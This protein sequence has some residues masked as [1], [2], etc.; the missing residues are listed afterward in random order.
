MT[1]TLHRLIQVRPIQLVF[2]GS[3]FLSAFLLFLVQP[4]VTRMLLPVY[5]G[6]PAVWNTALV[7][8]QVL[9]LLGYL[10]AFVVSRVRSSRATVVLHGAVVLLPVLVLPPAL[11][12]AMTAD[13]ATSTWPAARLLLTLGVLVGAP[14]FALSS[15]SS[16]IQWWWSRSGFRDSQ[17]P[18]WLYGASNSGSLLALLLYPFALERAFGVSQQGLLWAAGYGGF[19]VLTAAVMF[20]ALVRSSAS[21]QTDGLPETVRADPDQGSAEPLPVRRVLLW[22]FRSAVGSS[23]LLSVSTQITTDL[24]PTPLLWV[25]PLAL[26]LVTFILAFSVTERLH[27]P[28]LV[29]AA[30]AFLFG[31]LGLLVVG[32]R[33]RFEITLAIS[34]G[35]LFFGALLCHRD[36]AANRPRTAHLTAFYLW[37]S[38]GG[39]LGGTLNGLVAPLVFDSVAELPL[40][41]MALALLLYVDPETDRLAAYRPTWRA[42]LLV[43]L[44]LIVP[45]ISSLNVDGQRLIP[46]IVGVTVLWCLASARYVGMVGM[47]VVIAGGLILADPF[48]SG[49]V[50]ARERSFFGVIWVRDA[51]D[52]L[53]ML[54]GSTIHGSQSK[55]PAQRRLPGAYYHTGG[56]LGGA[57]LQAADSARIGI[58][59]LGTGGLAGLGRPGQHITYFEIDPL[60]EVMARQYFSFLADSPARVD[61]R[62]GDGRLEMAEL[63]DDSFDLLIVDAF[64]SDFIPIHLLTEEAIDV[65]VRKAR[66]GALMVFHISNRHA[67]LR[68]VLVSYAEARGLAI[69]HADFTPASEEAGQGARRTVVAALST[70][71]STIDVLTQ[72]EIWSREAVGVHPVRWTDDYSNLLSVLR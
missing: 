64:S 12:A 70:H 28:W 62:I 1:P 9:L 48:G 29:A 35:T 3:I 69:A 31:S 59:G 39:A 55:D 32:G 2:V 52:V 63:P 26:F 5:G 49:T 54:H 16:L 34:L 56:P 4:L 72:E 40:T 11:T 57:M 50:V 41:L 13:V 37:I 68:R 24:A 22:V 53:D 27:R 51:G 66:P 65:Y 45:L 61:V 20:H 46:A 18:Y 71:D 7:F 17:D 58:I 8:F 60:V 21:P 6:S 33:P 44:G 67:D 23:L 15:N 10:Y 38:F 25:V 42:A 14:F 30:T 47:T 19:V 43:G 36:L